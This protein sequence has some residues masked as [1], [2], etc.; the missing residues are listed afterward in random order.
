LTVIRAGQAVVCPAKTEAAT[1]TEEE[2]GTHPRTVSRALRGAVR[3]TGTRSDVVI[4]VHRHIKG[5]ATVTVD[6][7]R[8]AARTWCEADEA[9]ANQLQ[10][11]EELQGAVTHGL[12]RIG[13]D[14][15]AVDVHG[16]A[17]W[18]RSQRQGLGRD[19]DGTVVGIK[20]AL[21]TTY[22]EGSAGAVNIAL[23]Q[24]RACPRPGRIALLTRA[25]RRAVVDQPVATEL[26]QTQGR[27]A[28]P[29]VG[30]AVV[31]FLATAW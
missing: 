27:A 16:S 26:I 7:S 2:R 25:A 4:G 20:D 24:G 6:L 10:R 1:A 12:P 14:D 8:G 11:V 23:L 31:T 3:V 9:D 21:V 19:L 15:P 28:V 29:I 18:D 13:V 17:R 5:I 30:V 22:V